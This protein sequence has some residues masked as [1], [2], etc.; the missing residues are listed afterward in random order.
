MVQKIKIFNSKKANFQKFLETDFTKKKPNF[1]KKKIFKKIF[2][3]VSQKIWKI[4]DFRPFSFL[5]VFSRT[6]KKLDEECHEYYR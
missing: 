1:T 4:G 6:S 3:S 2:R 5:N